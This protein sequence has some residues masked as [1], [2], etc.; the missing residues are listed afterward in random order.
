M[1]EHPHPLKVRIEDKGELVRVKFDDGHD[2]VIV[3]YNPRA[4]FQC[5]VRYIKFYRGDTKVAQ[6]NSR[7]DGRDFNEL[8]TCDS[9]YTP[10]QL[11]EYLDL[12][13]RYIRWLVRA[14]PVGLHYADMVAG[15]SDSALEVM[16]HAD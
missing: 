4:V 15:A 10:G 8:Q 7:I 9:A 12:A 1:S 13:I 16:R 2:V 3:P 14:Y 5:W 11:A 6:F